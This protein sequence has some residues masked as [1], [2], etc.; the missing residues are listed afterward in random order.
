M[1]SKD[2]IS[3]VGLPLRQSYCR[4]DHSSSENSF[5]CFGQAMRRDRSLCNARTMTA[6][7]SCDHVE[8]KLGQKE[9]TST[10][11]QENNRVM[12]IIPPI[13]DSW[14]SANIPRIDAL[15]NNSVPRKDDCPCVTL[16]FR[17]TITSVSCAFSSS[18]VVPEIHYLYS[19]DQEPILSLTT[20]FSHR[21]SCHWTGFAL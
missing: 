4:I 18:S 6:R 19:R 10:Q 13:P 7:D 11:T 1:L 15:N 16:T 2:I 14:K 3:D 9:S 12:F 20:C 5:D 21:A 17:E 8:R